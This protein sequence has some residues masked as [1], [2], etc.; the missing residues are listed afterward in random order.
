[1]CFKRI[2]ILMA[3]SNFTFNAILHLFLGT[4]MIPVSWTEMQCPRTLAK[5]F[6]KVA[7]VVP[8]ELV[9]EL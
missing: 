9:N 1:M 3:S 6:R 8:E 4:S 7:K 5:E 2:V